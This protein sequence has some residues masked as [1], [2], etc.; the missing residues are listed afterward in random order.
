MKTTEV[1]LI[2][3]VFVSL[4]LMYSSIER[5]KKYSTVYPMSRAVKYLYIWLSVIFPPLGFLLT[6]SLVVKNQ[7]N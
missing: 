6:R 2:L 4:F 5:I 3:C 7:G 1:I